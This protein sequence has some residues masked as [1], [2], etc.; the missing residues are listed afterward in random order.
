M[1]LKFKKVAA[2]DN[3]PATSGYDDLNNNVA[4]DGEWD[5]SG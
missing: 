2:G 1:R 4:D 5:G 3:L